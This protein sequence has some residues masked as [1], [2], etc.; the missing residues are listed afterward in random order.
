MSVK[1]R[2]SPNKK[3]ADADAAEGVEMTS[4]STASS[5]KTED[6]SST[7]SSYVPSS[8]VANLKTFQQGMPMIILLASNKYPL[9]EFGPTPFRIAHIV[10]HMAVIA[11][12]VF[13]KGQIPLGAPGDKGKEEME[14]DVPAEESFGREIKPAMKLSREAY[15]LKEWGAQMQKIG[16]SCVILL[17]IHFQF[18]ALL[19]LA[20]QCFSVPCEL[21]LSPLFEIYIM[22]NGT[23]PRPF[24]QA[25]SPFG[26]MKERFGKL[27]E[28]MANQKEEGEDGEEKAVK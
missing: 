22:G 3:K 4:S 18:G 11:V 19:P 16:M 14:I 10:I 20:F 23:V 7:D 5:S 25:P 12:L 9:E 27:Q 1:K 28:E 6:S 17:L 15:D 26:E 24:P 2:G 13:I 8:Y 21:L